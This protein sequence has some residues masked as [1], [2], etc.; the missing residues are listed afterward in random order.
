MLKMGWLSEIAF[1]FFECLLIVVCPS[2]RISSL[3][4]EE[5]EP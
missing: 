5:K 3:Q 2:G 4:C 1:D